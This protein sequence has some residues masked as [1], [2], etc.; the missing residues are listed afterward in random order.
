MNT[1]A[2]TPSTCSAPAH[3]RVVDQGAKR[4]EDDDPHER[5]DDAGDLV[6]HED[7]DA[8]AER[9]AEDRGDD[10]AARH[11]DEVLCRVG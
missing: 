6:A 9:A 10:A 7:A 5:T 3:E 2:Q 11:R 8:D 4:L 1:A